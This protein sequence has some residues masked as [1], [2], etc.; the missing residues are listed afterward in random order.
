MLPIILRKPMAKIENN[1][2]EVEVIDFAD[3]VEHDGMP[4]RVLVSKITSKM[5]FKH[6]DI[7]DGS[8][9]FAKCM[10]MFVDNVV[11]DMFSIDTTTKTSFNSKGEMV[12]ITHETIS[13][14]TP[15]PTFNKVLFKEFDE[16]QTTVTL[17]GSNIVVDNNSEEYLNLLASET[18]RV[19]ELE[20]DMVRLY[21]L[22]KYDEN[23]NNVSESKSEYLIRMM[24]LAEETILYLGHEYKN[25]RKLDSSCRDYSINRFGFATEYG[26]AFEKNLIEPAQE[27]LVTSGGI[28]M[29]KDYLCDEFGVKSWRKLFEK[30]VF[31]VQSSSDNIEKD[32]KPYN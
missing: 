11:R 7:N 17:K 19:K 26:D 16:P 32:R 12:V 13:S 10:A 4:Y 1:C 23:K 6:Q 31:F 5:M 20:P 18:F 28:Q 30:A 8:F 3:E 27:Y 29:A 21:A 15:E 14:T 22:M 9:V 25:T 24:K 2:K